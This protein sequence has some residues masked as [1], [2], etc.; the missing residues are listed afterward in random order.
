[1][2]LE[3]QELK[4][5]PESN[6]LVIGIALGTKKNRACT[7]PCLSLSLFKA[8]EAARAVVVKVH[9]SSTV[10]ATTK[11]TQPLYRVSGVYAP[12]LPTL[13]IYPMQ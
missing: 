10:H 4:P 6:V 8:E 12:S 2:A 3:G 9:W 1:M 5:I 11:S 13:P 7:L